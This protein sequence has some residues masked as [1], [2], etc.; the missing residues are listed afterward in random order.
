MSTAPPR[1]ARVGLAILAFAVVYG[2][3]AS[4]GDVRG[5]AGK[6]FCAARRGARRGRDRTSDFSIAT[7]DA[8]TTCARVA[9][10]RARA[11]SNS[12][13]RP[14]S[15]R[16][17]AGYRRTELRDRLGSRRGF[18]WLKREITTKQRQTSTAS[19]CRAWLPLRE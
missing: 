3:I 16:R 12:M 2:A 7:A 8:A 13:K 1:R 15:D 10:R 17:A 11:G 14:A 18:V 4:A 19:A 5:G 9:V 6:P